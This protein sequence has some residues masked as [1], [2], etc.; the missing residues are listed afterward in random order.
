MGYIIDWYNCDIIDKWNLLDCNLLIGQLDYT[1]I[2]ATAN[3]YYKESLQPRVLSASE[4]NIYNW[5]LI[6]DN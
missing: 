4:V 5:S 3:A 6:I 2:Q 1:D